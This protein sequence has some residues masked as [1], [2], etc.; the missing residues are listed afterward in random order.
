MT[1]CILKGF[2]ITAWIGGSDEEI[3]GEWNWI[4]S[5]R[6][7]DDHLFTDW[8]TNHG[9]APRTD[10]QDCLKLT[11]NLENGHWTDANCGRDFNVIC[12]F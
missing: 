6:P 12:Q 5:G 10:V 8:S 3:E 7:I 9:S 1:I 2:G 4:T 11:N